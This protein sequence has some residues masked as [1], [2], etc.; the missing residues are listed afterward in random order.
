L[1][2]NGKFVVFNEQ[3]AA[4]EG[5]LGFGAWCLEFP[6]PNFRLSPFLLNTRYQMVLM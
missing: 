6:L 3:I 5:G 1:S 2:E 4:G